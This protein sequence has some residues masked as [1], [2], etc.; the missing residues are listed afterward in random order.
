VGLVGLKSRKYA[1]DIALEGLEGL[2]PPMLTREKNLHF[3]TVY[4]GGTS[5]TSP[6]TAIEI[7]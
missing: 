2:T 6:T 5:P 7:A 4:R 3:R 1:I